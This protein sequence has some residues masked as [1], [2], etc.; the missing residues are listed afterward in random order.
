MPA[1]WC[2]MNEVSY[3][4]LSVSA[5]VVG[6]VQPWTG[7]P[8][9]GAAAS[10]ATV[11]CR[12]S[13]CPVA[14]VGSNTSRPCAP[15]CSARRMTGMASSGVGV[16]AKCRL[17]DPTAAPSARRA[18]RARQQAD[19]PGYRP[20]LR[21]RRAASRPRRV[22][23]TARQALPP[24]R[25]GR[26]GSRPARKDFVV[27]VGDDGE[28]GS[29]GGYPAAAVHAGAPTPEGGNFKARRA[30]GARGP[31]ATGSRWCLRLGWRRR[32]PAMGFRTCLTRLAS[33][34]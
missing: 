23:N 27:G 18:P 16:S 20:A 8:T 9:L 13:G 17:G 4:L 6:G 5:T 29:P 14:P 1:R 28:N 7:G 33:P 26:T 3:S 24:D 31:V 34:S 12:W 19:W 32:T 11:A 30:S 22:S 15:D 21:R 2:P 25:R 10:A